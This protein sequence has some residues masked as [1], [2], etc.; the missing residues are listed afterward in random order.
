M[1]EENNT[2]IQEPRRLFTLLGDVVE[3]LLLNGLV[4]YEALDFGGGA[5]HVRV[6]GGK[7]TQDNHQRTLK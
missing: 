3:A 4:I 5:V 1:K 2:Y 6:L 7:P